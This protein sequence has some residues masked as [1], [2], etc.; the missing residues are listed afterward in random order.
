MKEQIFLCSDWTAVELLI[1][2]CWVL[3]STIWPLHTIPT[4]TSVYAAISYYLKLNIPGTT[5]QSFLSVDCN[6]L[7]FAKF[8]VFF[9][10]RESAAEL[11]TLQKSGKGGG[12]KR[13]LYFHFHSFILKYQ[14]AGCLLLCFKTIWNA[15][16]G[17]ILNHHK[18]A[19]QTG[20]LLQKVVNLIMLPPKIPCFGEILKVW[21]HL[22]LFCEFSQVK[23]SQFNRNPCDLEFHVK[24][25]DFPTQI[26]E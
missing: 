15:Y 8:A 26:S 23:S 3:A 20:R 19:L 5:Q 22:P 12:K 13:S 4:E 25:K 11:S 18:T 14:S 6:I 2:V 9:C 17:W 10:T 24:M 1:K 7:P 21:S 16:G